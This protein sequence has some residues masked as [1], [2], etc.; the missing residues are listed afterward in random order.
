MSWLFSNFVGVMSKMGELYSGGRIWGHVT[1]VLVIGCWG[2]TFV[3][4]K[5]LVNEGMSPAEIFF[6]RFLLAYLSILTISPRRWFCDRWRDEL[7][8]VLLGVTGGSVYFLAENEAIRLSYVN[9]VSFIVC[10]APLIT[11]CLATALLHA[12][13]ATPRLVIGSLVAL[14]G[15]ALVICNGRLV[16][17]LSPWGD[18]LA[19]LAAVCWAVYSLIMR[20]VL[21][22]YGAVFVTRKVF[23]YGLLTILPVFLLRPWAF[24]PVLLL[25]PVIWGNVLFL[26][27]LA[28][29]V[30]YVLWNWAISRLGAVTTSNYV[31]LNPIV[32]LVASAIFLDE[33]MTLMAYAG[34]ALI[35]AGVYVANKG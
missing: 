2:C 16:L 11:T 21:E 15:V 13:R 7:I 9:N 28:S 3:S 6:S 5:C 34:C 18:L 12:V 30:C 8:M 1:A 14:A 26:G 32:T 23:F 24:E 29:F 31:Y 35:L 19:L 22:R 4:T 10:T 27:L 17:Q 25:R 33:P 20:P